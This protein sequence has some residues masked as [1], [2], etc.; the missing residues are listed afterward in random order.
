MVVSTSG[1]FRLLIVT[2]ISLAIITLT[3]HNIPYA[4]IPSSAAAYDIRQNNYYPDAVQRISVEQD[5]Q[6]QVER[7]N[8]D[9][10]NRY[11]ETCPTSAPTS[12]PPPTPTAPT[13]EK[14]EDASQSFRE[15]YLEQPAKDNIVTANGTTK[16]GQAGFLTYSNNGD[17]IRIQY[18][19]DWQIAEHKNPNRIYSPIVTFYS[20]YESDSDPYAEVVDVTAQN[21][22]GQDR[23]LTPEQYL[24]K[25]VSSYRQQNPSFRVLEANPTAPFG[26]NTL[27]GYKL[28]FTITDRTDDSNTILK[29]TEMGTLDKE[30]NK[31]YFVR[32]FV[33]ER[34]DSDYLPVTEKMVS[35][36]ELIR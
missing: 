16:P 32:S 26:L 7:G 3:Q 25:V 12:T 14:V 19:S 30:V 15:K 23:V 10:C 6:N 35:T 28:V 24:A 11:L 20:P 22:S 2:C 18:P 5:E 29:V 33:E 27:P 34:K 17:K 8:T 21:L 31:A 4:L 1:S 36:F 9:I 13:R